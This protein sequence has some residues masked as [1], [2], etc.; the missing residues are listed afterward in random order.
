[1]DK[2]LIIAWATGLLMLAIWVFLCSMDTAI[3]LSAAGA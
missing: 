3:F 1:M 2:D